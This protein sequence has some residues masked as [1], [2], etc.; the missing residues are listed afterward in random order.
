VGQYGGAE[1]EANIFHELLHAS[2]GSD[3]WWEHVHAF[4]AEA[5][6]WEVAYY[7]FERLPLVL[8]D[9]QDHPEWTLFRHDGYHTWYMYG[10]ALFLLYL[11]DHAFQGNLAFS[12]EM[13][14]RSRNAPGAA[15]DPSLNEPDFTDALQDLLAAR[16]S[17][18]FAE[19]VGFARARWYTGAGQ[20]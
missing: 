20:R 2:Q 1:L 8:R 18:L 9:Y 17:S 11:R 6:L 5:T 15:G 19:I 10:G 3:D 14:H 13:W 16:D 7:G 12:N 4:E